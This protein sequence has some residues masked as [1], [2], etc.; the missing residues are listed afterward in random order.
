MDYT[1]T[2]LSRTEHYRG[3]I[4]YVHT[5]TVRLP[6]GREAR[7]EIVEHPGGVVVLPI[8]ADGNVYCV[9]QY[10][11]A[12]GTHLLELPAG[13]LEV[14]EE[15]LS[16]AMRELS[17]ETGCTAARYI[18][19]GA[20]CP[21]PG[22]CRE[23]LYLYLATGL[24]RGAQHLDEGEFLDV[25]RFPLHELERMTL[26]G[27]LRDAKTVAAVLKARYYLNQTDAGEEH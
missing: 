27:E 9:R 24:Q 21:S 1:E 10:R 26:T 20:L 11:Y 15:L 4:I 6:D 16:C 19:M 14:G 25:E 13:K 8:D 17:E 7:R 5:D 18:P 2:M 22:Y 3:R 12:Y 23:T